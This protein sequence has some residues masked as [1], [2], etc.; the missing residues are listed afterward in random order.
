MEDTAR[1][2]HQGNCCG[3]SALVDV[4]PETWPLTNASGTSGRTGSVMGWLI[5]ENLLL[6]VM[7]TSTILP[8]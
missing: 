1:N 7:M 4:K 8:I 5:N 3:S 2:G 6:D